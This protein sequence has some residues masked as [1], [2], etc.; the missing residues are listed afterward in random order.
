MRDKGFKW[1]LI[2]IG[3][4]AALLRFGF[5]SFLHHQ[6]MQSGVTAWHGV[7]ALCI[8]K[9][10][11]F[12]LDSALAYRIQTTQNER[13][14]LVDPEEFIRQGWELRPDMQWPSM[15]VPGYSFLL[16]FFWGF[17]PAKYIF[18]Q[19]TLITLDILAALA[20][21][22]GIRGLFGTVSGIISGLLY[23]IF[24][25]NA[26]FSC[27]ASRDHFGLLGIV[28]SFSFL[29]LYLK[30][31]RLVYLIASGLI[32]GLF[33]WIR[34]FGVLLPLFYGFGIAMHLGFRK[35]LRDLLVMFCVLGAVFLLPFSLFN[36]ALY[37]R[38]SPSTPYIPISQ[39]LGEIPN[40]YGFQNS[41]EYCVQEAQ[42]AL[43]RESISLMEVGDYWKE[44][45]L[46]VAKSDPA[47]I[48]KVLLHRAM[49][50][51]IMG[52]TPFLKIPRE[53]IGG[54]WS[55]IEIPLRW[56]LKLT[57]LWM[58]LCFALTFW[59]RG[60][61]TPTLLLIPGL[62]YFFSIFFYRWPDPRYYYP[63]LISPL[64]ILAV[65][66]GILCENMHSKVCRKG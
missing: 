65:T 35:G 10:K 45:V 29:L 28:F 55:L 1:W 36:K 27:F 56:F 38:F 62:G 44:K 7:H 37:N 11:P 6:Y 23:A 50:V 64:L 30:E 25:I 24:P 14:R 60:W 8:T 15:D 52:Y 39:G 3:L 19:I 21:T 13:N 31:K 47:F 2:A 41:D 16:A 20:L 12:N 57:V 48:G 5:L 26:M 58:L 43:G 17:F 18:A 4:T 49:T 51:P 46:S 32:L 59:K 9:G 42:K 63:W 34:P 61:R 22:I 66:I 33:S 54:W 40:S 53:H